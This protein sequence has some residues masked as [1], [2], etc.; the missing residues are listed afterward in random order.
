LTLVAASGTV[1][2]VMNL[3]TRAYWSDA[4]Y[5]TLPVLPAGK[6]ALT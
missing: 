5:F 6:M 2:C 3:R 4:Y 1:I